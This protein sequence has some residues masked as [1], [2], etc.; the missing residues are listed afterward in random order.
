MDQNRPPGCIQE[1]QITA[2]LAGLDAN[3]KELTAILP[4]FKQMIEFMDTMEQA[5]LDLTNTILNKTAEQDARFIVIPR[6]L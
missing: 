4:A 6:V 1:L 2:R 3:E 5:D